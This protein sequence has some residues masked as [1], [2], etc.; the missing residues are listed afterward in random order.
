MLIV[1]VWII[2]TVEAYYIFSV[3]D[4]D[5]I[6]KLEIFENSFSFSSSA[7]FNLMGDLQ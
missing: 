1:R 3:Q 6:S 2:T 7:V 5:R 4:F